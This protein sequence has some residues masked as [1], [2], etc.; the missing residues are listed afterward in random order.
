M[1]ISQN[2]KKYFSVKPRSI[3]QHRLIFFPYA[4]G[5]GEVYTPWFKHFLGGIECLYTQLPGRGARFHE[6]AFDQLNPLVDSILPEILEL[7]DCSMSFFGHSM[8][9][10]IAFEVA[11][12]LERDYNMIPDTLFLSGHRSPSLQHNRKFLHDLPEEELMSHLQNMGGIDYSQNM[13]LDLIRPFLPTLRSDFKL[14]ETYQY[15]FRT[16][17]NSKLVILWGKNDPLVQREKI[18][19]WKREASG[20][21]EFFSYEG[22]HFYINQHYREISNLMEERI[23]N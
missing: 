14:C 17:L 1:T 5:S 23:F 19:F 20:T 18:H 6:K 2:Y 22:D 13:S 15:T 12:R 7:A 4:G 10:L 21:V 3:P 9:A 16:P 8:G 11:H